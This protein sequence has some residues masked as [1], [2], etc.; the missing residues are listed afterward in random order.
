ML[1]TVA[2]TAAF[3]QD[4]AAFEKAVTEFTLD[5][6]MHFIVLERHEAPVV[7]FHTHADAGSVDDP[8]G[9]TGLAHMFEHVAFKG[10]P[11]I[12]SKDYEKEKQALEKVDQAY[13]ALVGERRK[14]PRAEA[15]RLEELQAAFQEAAREAAV[16]AR[17]DEFTRIIEENGG[18][19]LNAGTSMDATMYMSRLPSNR[20]ELWFYLESERFLHPVYR[21]FYKERDVVREERRLRIES[22]PLGRLLESFLAAAYQAHPYGR[23]GVGWAEDIDNLSVEDAAAFFKTYYGPSNLTVGIAGDVDPQQIRRWAEVYF[24][25]LQ[26]RPPPPRVETKEP[27]QRGER[28]VEVVSEAQPSIL[29]GYHKP[30]HHHPDRAVF[31]VISS[32]LSSGRT[33][34]LYKELVR[35][36]QIALFA[37]GFPDFPGSKYGSLF[38]FFALPGPEHAVDEVEQ[39]MSEVIERMKKTP[40]DAATL[41]MVKTKARAGLIRRLDGTAGLAAELAAN[42]AAFGDWRRIFR[43][44]EEIEAVTAEDVQRVARR[45]F[46]KTARTT[47]YSVPLEPAQE[48]PA[49]E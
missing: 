22:D 10:T 49:G 37:G 27:E 3:A 21:E 9:R 6:G 8:A 24:G 16:W 4:Q 19:G 42:H 35:D 39:A 45:Y 41:E 47:A 17:G 32:I 26:R 2:A 46:R 25:R 14:G 7:S 20:A 28:R 31:D 29:I 38:V 43:Q 5:N 15:E 18:R 11:V 40:V 48:A 30:S 36:R 34:W 44:L 23:P 33:S 12:G 1:A 13:R